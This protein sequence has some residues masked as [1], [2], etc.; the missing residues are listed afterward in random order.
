MQELLYIS[1]KYLLQFNNAY[2]L[3]L[4]STYISIAA[5]S[6]NDI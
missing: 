1:H 6:R 3:E 2:L 4:T 5:T